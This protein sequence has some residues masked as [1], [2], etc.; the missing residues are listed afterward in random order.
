MKPSIKATLRNPVV[1]I[2]NVIACVILCRTASRCVDQRAVSLLNGT[3]N[4]VG[5][6]VPPR[7][8]AI[9]IKGARRDKPLVGMNA[10]AK[11]A[12]KE[13]MLNKPLGIDV[14]IELA[15]A[16]FPDRGI[17][18]PDFGMGGDW[19]IWLKCKSNKE[20]AS[21]ARFL[22][23]FGKK[24]AGPIAPE[25]WAAKTSVVDDLYDNAKARFGQERAVTLSFLVFPRNWL[26]GSE[27]FKG[28]FIDNANR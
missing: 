14:P 11:A 27:N 1:L 16:V 20:S 7:Q 24:Y 23:Q 28:F 17:R 9:K 19:G 6:T 25:D 21:Y 15:M 22:E 10:G 3:A 4:E 13:P 18:H 5:K 12:P 2:C 26:A 8:K